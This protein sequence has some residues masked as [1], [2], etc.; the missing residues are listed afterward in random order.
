M[1]YIHL[2]MRDVGAEVSEKVSH[3]G[4]ISYTPIQIVINLGLQPRSM[5]GMSLIFLKSTGN[6]EMND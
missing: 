4:I 1:K 5:I 2:A 6:K 3:L